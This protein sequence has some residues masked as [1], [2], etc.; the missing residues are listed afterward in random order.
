[1]ALV[2]S[3]G[4]VHVSMLALA[5]AASA[6]I[7]Q[8]FEID[9]NVT[10]D[11]GGKDWAS[12]GTHAKDPVGNVDTSTFGQGSKEFQH[13]STWIQKTG[14]APN[15][16]DI[17]DVY[18]YNE[19]NAAGEEWG[20]FGFRRLTTTGVT[21]YDVEFNQEDN[22]SANPARPTRTAGDLM[23]RFEQNGSDAFTLT[24]AYIWTI[25]GA[26]TWGSNCLL[27]PGYDPAAGWCQIST[28]AAGFVGAT[29]ESGHFAEG[30]LNLSSFFTGTD[31]R[32]GFG[33]ANIRSFTGEAD[34]SS[35]KD[36][37]EPVPISVPPTCGSMLFRK[38]DQFG[39]SVGGATYQI[40]PNPAP[41]S[42]PTPPLTVVDNQAPDSDPRAGWIEIDP[43]SP[44]T[45][46]VTETVAP[47][48]YLLPPEGER[49]FEIVV[50][51]DG[52]TTPIRIFRD[53]RIFKPL[54]I[55]NDPEA[56]YDVEYDWKVEK[57]VDRQ[58]A[59]VPEG[60]PADFQYTVKLSALSEQKSGFE[61]HGTVTLGNPNAV[62]M[63]ATLDT[64]ITGGNACTFVTSL[65]DPQPLEDVSSAAGFQVNVPTGSN[66]YDYV[67]DPGANP[68][69]SGTSTAT[70]SWDAATY[71]QEGAN[72]SYTR[73]HAVD[74]TYTIDQRTDEQVT[75]TDVF[76][77]QQPGKDL[78]T[79]TWDTFVG[80]GTLPVTKTIATYKR[81]IDGVPG[82]CTSYPNKVTAD[83]NDTTDATDDSETVQ[84]CVGRNL[85]IDKIATLSY[86]RVYTWDVAKSGP[87]T[88]FTGDDGQGNYTTEV[89][90]KVDL[91]AVG[92]QDSDRQ[93]AGQV[94]LSNPNDWAV[95][96]TLVDVATVDGQ[97]YPCTF[98]AADA[99]PGTAGHQVSVPADASS[100]SYAYTCP[101]VPQGNYVGTNTATITWDK[102]EYFTPGETA[103]KT[104]DINVAHDPTPANYNI[105]LADV[106]DGAPVGLPQSSFNWDTVRAMAGNTQTLTYT[107]TLDT[108][109]GACEPH[110]NTVTIS[111]TGQDA[112][113]T[114]EV[115]APGVDKTYDAS[116][117]RKRLWT[118][119]KDV[120][121]TQ[122]EIAQGG[123]ATFTYTVKAVP[124]DVVD[125]GSAS[126][127][128]TVSVKNPSAT[129]PLT[130]DVT[131][132]SG[133]TG[134]TCTFTSSGKDTATGVK[135][136]PKATVPLAYTCQ[137][138]GHPD[139]N[140][141]ARVTFGGE[142]VSKTIPIAFKP[143]GTILDSKVTITDDKTNQDVPP[144]FLFDADFADPS[145]W[146]HTYQLTKTGAAGTCTSYTNNAVLDLTASPNPPVASE[147]VEVCVEKP[148]TLA[149]T[150]AADLERSYTWGI[151]KV[152]DATRR[153]VDPSTGTAKFHY[154]V[155]VKA[156][157]AVDSGWA[158]KGTIAITNPNEYAGG[159]ITADITD[160][161]MNVGGGVTCTV[162]GGQDVVIP[163]R[164]GDQS[165]VV[166]LPYTCSFTGAPTD[167]TNVASA[168]WTPPGSAQPATASTSPAPVAFAVRAEH[169]KVVDVVD[170]K[171]VPGQRIVLE[172]DLV[173][174]SGLTK[175]YEYDLSVAGGARGACLDHTNT[176]IVD[177]TG[178]GD[179]SDSVTVTACTPPLPPVVTAP[180][181]PLV[182]VIAEQES[183]KAVGSL[184]ATCQGTVRA[185]LRNSRSSVAV[186]Q[187]RIGT[188]KYAVRVKPE[189][190]K[191]WEGHGK[192][193]V[194]VSL[195]ESGKVLDRLRMP[196]A[197][198]L[199]EVLPDT[200]K[201]PDSRTSW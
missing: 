134:W 188:K 10:V 190:R 83:E 119:T 84:V 43:A 115:C 98:T 161:P 42:A 176:A 163:A 109:A 11:A 104:V 89:T 130:V 140:N 66:Q 40:S 105:T 47:P 41:G 118:V 23:V 55:T 102:Q 181:P 69:A 145:T 24:K 101:G 171:T 3:L 132:V 15:Q 57:S 72:P 88:V 141:T 199:P 175:S 126:W 52:M 103:T 192:P 20:F 62:G 142:Q 97:A 184:A 153:D 92:Y 78:G 86:D 7:V 146:S 22:T 95:E 127:T 117:G 180:P 13:P 46:T 75:V 93:L 133:V 110:L 85:A 67:C 51:E 116:H 189:S 90:Y 148:L 112:S 185:R 29:G 4:V 39:N 168:S 27:V 53:P 120:D 159:A 135:I 162:Q 96:V 70:A 137:G 187:V 87:G 28:A 1:M 5:P 121:E 164:A 156:G 38:V 183:G 34:A 82:S 150:V 48:G 44:G 60:T 56:T 25:Q 30:A 17:S 99:D 173:W 157:A 79:F 111:P 193:Q 128:G 49:S 100:Q 18:F 165:G 166:T 14:L 33:T 81:T 8:G 160:T 151:E 124:G 113:H 77:G 80:G 186:Y 147:T 74:Y 149:K 177:M 182:E 125:D 152:A 32:G 122:V 170:D 123:A 64:T 35:L 136:A 76:N 154:T 201:R 114:V 9:G 167:G 108:T 169:D 107:R 37:V 155:T 178:A 94:F 179:P 196:R 91:K 26:G 19:T 16:D 2:A 54:T 158:M 6:A 143:S 58:S 21:N 31:C 50:D 45:Y 106:L 144:G 200:G 198:E 138:A 129:T 191:L 194:R 59:N 71:P 12:T 131:D 195:R 63:V 139:G 174:S 197:C 61:V 65:A 73:T 36:Y 172:E 68:A